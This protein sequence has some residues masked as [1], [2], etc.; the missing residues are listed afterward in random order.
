M[1]ERFAD[2]S[3][4][5][6]EAGRQHRSMR[7][8]RY[9]RTF[10]NEILNAQIRYQRFEHIRLLNAQR[11]TKLVQIKTGALRIALVRF[12]DQT[13]CPLSQL[14]PSLAIR[15]YFT[16]EHNFAGELQPR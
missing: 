3:L 13:G 7:S 12:I 1:R 6:F 8:P 16:A 9:G 11:R 2:P 14:L 4:N 15:H 5:W 10:A